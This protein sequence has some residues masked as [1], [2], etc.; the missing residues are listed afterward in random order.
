MS[1]EKIEVS[2]A[3]LSELIA[4]NRALQEQLRDLKQAVD[5]TNGR[6]TTQKKSPKVHTARVRAID[7]KIVT[8]FVNRGV[9]K[10]PLYVYERN[11]PSNPRER[12]NYVDLILEDNSVVSVPHLEFLQEAETVE[13]KIIDEKVIQLSE[14]Q[15][16]VTRKE[17]DFTKYRTVDT[18]EEVDAEVVMQESVFTLELPE[19]YGKRQIELH[20]S[21]LNTA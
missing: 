10:R 4:S 18:G 21:I 11:N 13:A 16:K 17:V 5:E 20:G 8:G 1:D 14:S 15:G 3:E 7:G 9:E 6:V 2:R 12:V 19:E